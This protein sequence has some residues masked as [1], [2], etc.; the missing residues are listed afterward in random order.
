VVSHPA[1]FVCDQGLVQ[2]VRAVQ[3]RVRAGPGMRP[4]HEERWRLLPEMVAMF[5]QHRVCQAETKMGCREAAAG[6]G[7]ELSQRDRHAAPEL[8]QR[9]PATWLDAVE[10]LLQDTRR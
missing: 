5:R 1:L 10:Q 7:A 2:V 9:S 3:G 8:F 6:L 4:N